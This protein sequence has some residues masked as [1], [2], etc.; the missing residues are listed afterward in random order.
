MEGILATL[1]GIWRIVFFALVSPS[2]AGA[3]NSR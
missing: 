1:Q 3:E 2:H